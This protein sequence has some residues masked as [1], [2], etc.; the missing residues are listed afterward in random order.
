[1]TNKAL[2]QKRSKE[3]LAVKTSLWKLRWMDSE[4][5]NLKRE[6]Q[7]LSNMMEELLPRRNHSV[8]HGLDTLIS[9]IES[10]KLE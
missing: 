3:E 1:M 8:L 6:K 4:A 10:T 9:L 5:A 7:F 2:E